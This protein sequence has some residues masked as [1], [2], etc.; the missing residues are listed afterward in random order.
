MNKEFFIKNRKKIIISVVVLA[1][2]LIAFSLINSTYSLFFHEDIASNTDNYTTGLLSI[3]AKGNSENISLTDALPMSDEAGA[4]STPYIF[5][6]TNTGNLDYKFNVK[7]LS[8]GDSSTSIDTRYIR[9]KVDDGEVATLADLTNGIIK[10]DITLL[11][12]ESIDITIRAWLNINTPNS[13]IGKTFNSK[14][15]TD[16]QAVYTSSNN[17]I[18]GGGAK[19]IKDLFTPDDTV[20]N[21]NIT[22]QYDTTH[23]LMKDVGGNIRYYGASPN[24]YIYFNCSDYTNQSSSTCEV[25]RIIGVIDGKL[26][27]V[28]NGN[29]DGYAWDNKNTSTGAE[30]D[31]GSNDWTVSRLMKMLNSGYESEIGGSLYWNRKNGT[32]YTSGTATAAC[33]FSSVGLI[34]DTTRNMIA[35]ATWYLGG[36]NA[37]NVYADFIY[38]KERGSNVYSGRPLSWNG[39]IALLYP[40]DYGYGAD[41]RYCSNNLYQYN[42]STCLSNNWISSLRN[43]YAMWLL[44][45]LSSSTYRVLVIDN[46]NRINVRDAANDADVIPTLYLNSSVSFSST[47]N[48]SQSN[49]YQIDINNSSMETYTITYDLNG[50]TGTIPSQT[51]IAGQPLTL[52]SVTPTKTKYA[53]GGWYIQGENPILA[54]KYYPGNSFEID[55]NITLVA[56]WTVKESEIELYSVV[57]QKS[58]GTTMTSKSVN[59][60]SP[61]SYTWSEGSASAMGISRP[62]TVSCTNGQT[63]ILSNDGDSYTVS[64]A[65]VTSNTVCTVTYSTNSGQVDM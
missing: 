41:F 23:N 18:Y 32:C 45:P 14:I 34:N 16:G 56:F 5:T 44:S 63:A 43:E 57:L 38:G 1:V 10:S 49:P 15:V 48:G 36:W 19:T 17:D 6:I 4:T 27:L 8:T 62:K 12:G 29:I 37:G 47:G 11:A 33:D 42:D 3:T 25:W 54:N 22:Y 59:A 7:L 58:S 52:S 35:S 51:K 2:F 24:N 30:N 61:F 31:F 26:K 46:Q 40:S 53:F 9:V 60:N 39:K 50:G 28:R 13:Q 55:G 65:S 64:I 21:N 20:V